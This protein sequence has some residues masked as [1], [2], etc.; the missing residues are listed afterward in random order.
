MC[1]T[2]SVCMFITDQILIMSCM[3]YI[4]LTDV[5]S[6]IKSHEYC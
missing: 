4:S 1:H 3:N 2:A 5:F 6:L